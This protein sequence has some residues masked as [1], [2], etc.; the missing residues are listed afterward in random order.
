MERA[1]RVE[2]RAAAI[3]VDGERQDPAKRGER[4]G[5]PSRSIP[6]CDPIHRYAAGRREP[7][8]GIQLGTAASVVD[9]KRVGRRIEP[10]AERRPVRSIPLRDAAHRHATRCRER[11]ARVES[12]TRSVIEDGERV[13]LEVP[14]ATQARADRGPVRAVPAG[15]P[16]RG[17][18][19][20]VRELATREQDWPIALVEL[21][22]GVD[23]PVRPGL[24]AGHRQPPGLATRGHGLL[25]ESGQSQDTRENGQEERTDSLIEV[26]EH[27][28]WP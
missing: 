18:A 20:D 16:S 5:R 4:D 23:R 8:A 2:S 11:S 26:R 15:D 7:S 25:C 6:P 22:H 1:A 3:V 12:S 19:S 27:G 17:N 28:G 14:H 13:D 10:A 24:T 21:H 9:R